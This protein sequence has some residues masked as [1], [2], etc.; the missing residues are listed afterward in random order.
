MDS[1][2]LEGMFINGFVQ[3]RRQLFHSLSLDQTESNRRPKQLRINHSHSFDHYENCRRG[4]PLPNNLSYS[5]EQEDNGSRPKPPVITCK[6]S[7][8]EFNLSKSHSNHS[9]SLSE[10]NCHPRSDIHVNKHVS[11]TGSQIIGDTTI[12]ELH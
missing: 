9:R 11:R 4:K 6:N 5:F 7:W 12:L 2:E 8:S 1:M 10:D 3:S